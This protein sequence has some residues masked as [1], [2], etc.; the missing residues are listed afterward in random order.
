MAAGALWMAP[1]ASAAQFGPVDPTIADGDPGSLR[2]IIENE[3]DDPAGDTVVL[4]AGATYTLLCSEGGQ[5]AHD[6]ATPLTIV[7][8]GATITIE[9]TCEERIL[10][11]TGDVDGLLRLENLTITGGNIT[12]GGDGGGVHSD[13]PVEIVGSTFTDNHVAPGSSSGGALSTQSTVSITDSYVSGNSSSGLGGGLLAGDGATVTRT[14]IVGNTGNTSGGSV[15]GAGIAGFDGDITVVASTVSGNVS[16]GP[17]GAGGGIAIYDGD[18][19]VTIVN[20]TVTGNSVTNGPG[21]GVFAEDVVLVYATVTGNSAPT[22]ANLETLTLTS[23]GSVVTG[24]TGGGDNCLVRSPDSLGWNF[25]DDDSCSFTN[26]ANGDREGAG[27]DPVLGALGGNGGPTATRLPQSGS[28]LIDAI[29]NAACQTP[30]VAVGI[31][32][33]QRG[34]ARPEA[35]GGACDIGAVEVQIEPVVVTPTFTG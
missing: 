22:A 25:A 26:V 19:T 5:L 31:T 28:P 7:G 13:G 24:P 21:G 11:H 30:P 8:N 29:P 27:L 33:D 35:A 18:G 3:A 12:A 9:S 17:D 20:S 14:S 1:A 15:S 10:D 23:F 32:T 4:T 16:P 2:D 6:P 34:F